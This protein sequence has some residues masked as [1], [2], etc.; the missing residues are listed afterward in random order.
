MTRRHFRGGLIYELDLPRRDHSFEERP[1][2]KDGLRGT[3][4]NSFYFR[5]VKQW[6]ELPREVV[7][8]PSVTVFKKEI[9]LALNTRNLNYCK[10]ERFAEA[11]DVGFYR[12]S[13]NFLRRDCFHLFV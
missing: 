12:L 3:Q 13:F 9:D 11:D 7:E 4:T 6:N 5:S 2:A 8:S 10:Q 1:F